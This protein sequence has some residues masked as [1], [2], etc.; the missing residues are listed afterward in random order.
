MAVVD[1]RHLPL[2]PAAVAGEELEIPGE[3]FYFYLHFDL[4]PGG[5]RRRRRHSHRLNGSIV[6]GHCIADDLV[7]YAYFSALN[8]PGLVIINSF[9]LRFSVN[10]CL[11]AGADT[12]IARGNC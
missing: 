8:E 2:L 12:F 3:I 9:K 5:L 11:V 6:I 10:L 1:V 4:L 7:A